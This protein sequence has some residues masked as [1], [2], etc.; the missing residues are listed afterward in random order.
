LAVNAYRWRC[1]PAIWLCGLER[2]PPGFGINSVVTGVHEGTFHGAYNTGSVGVKLYQAPDGSKLFYGDFAEEGSYL[3][4]K[5]AMHEGELQ[6]PI[7]LP[8]D[9]T[10]SGKLSPDGQ[11][12]S[13]DY[14][15]TMPPFDHGT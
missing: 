9:G 2:Y 1:L 3:H 4:F 7:L 13:G 14:Q 12:L 8:L 15:F 5:G 6:G 10:I 11:P